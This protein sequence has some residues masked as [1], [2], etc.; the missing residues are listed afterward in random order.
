MTSKS[1]L[2]DNVFDAYAQ[3][4]WRVLPDLTLSYGVRYEFYAPYTEKSGH[5]GV[6]DTNPSQGFTGLAEV[7]S[8]GVGPF[9][10]RLPD[11][12]VFPFRKRLR[13]GWGWRCACPR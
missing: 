3:D 11:G 12:L 2:R 10:G 9:N 8:G 13:R 6:V 1:Y 7:Q 5:L 4:D